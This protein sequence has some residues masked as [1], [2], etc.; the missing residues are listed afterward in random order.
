MNLIEQ[1][2]RHEGLRLKPYRCTSDKLTIGIGRNLEDVGITEEEARMLLKNDIA[3]ATT[4][5]LTEYPWMTTLGEVRFAAL[6]N[7]TFNVGIGT[8]GKFVKALALL[9]EQQFD[10][11]ADEFLKSRWARQVGQRAVEVT[12]QIR[13]G[14]WQ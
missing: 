14:E 2:E 3:N 12:D 4:Q 13:T 8:V 10:K 9:K 7:F 1:L 6:L 5:L 11:A